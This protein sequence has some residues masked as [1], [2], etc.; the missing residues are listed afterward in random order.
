MSVYYQYV[1]AFIW[2]INILHGYF[3]GETVLFSASLPFNILLFSF[4]V[5]ILFVRLRP[6][7]SAQMFWCG[8]VIRQKLARNSLYIQILFWI[9]RIFIHRKEIH[10]IEIWGWCKRP[11][12]WA[13]LS[14]RSN[15][16]GCYV[17]ILWIEQRVHGTRII[18]IIASFTIA[19]QL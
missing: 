14:R 12:F 17:Q 10:W 7:S 2:A 9:D 18:Q 5:N 15:I 11:N 8:S 4:Y 1:Y 3:L 19:N 13:N 16:S 6:C